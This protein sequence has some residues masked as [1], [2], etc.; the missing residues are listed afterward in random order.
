MPLSPFFFLFVLKESGN[1]CLGNGKLSFIHL[2]IGSHQMT[3]QP[4]SNLKRLKSYMENLKS[5]PEHESKCF[6]YRARDDEIEKRLH[7]FSHSFNKCL[8]RPSSAPGPVLGTWRYNK[9]NKTINLL[10]SRS[11]QED[12]DKHLCIHRTRQVVISTME[13]KKKRMSLLLLSSHLGWLSI[14]LIYVLYLNSLLS[15]HCF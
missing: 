5:W 6:V 10:P 12:P 7:S 1:I 4:E 14:S 9:V 2:R 3:L 11:Y 13:K 8:L 15:T